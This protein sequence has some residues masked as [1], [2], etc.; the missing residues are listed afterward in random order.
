MEN[1]SIGQV[2]ISELNKA[3]PQTLI[4]IDLNKTLYSITPSEL[5]IIEEGSTKIWKDITLTG[6]GIGVPCAINAVIEYNKNS[7]FN[8]EVF[9]NSLVGG[10]CIALAIISAFIWANTESKCKALI[11]EIKERPKYKMQ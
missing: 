6:L 1:S 2:D 5:T 7:L 8:P 10:I 11:K 4:H 3:L 9:W